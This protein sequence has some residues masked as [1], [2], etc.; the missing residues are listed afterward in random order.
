[1][2]TPEVP[3]LSKVE[4]FDHVA[5]IN[6]PFEDDPQISPLAATHLR[7]VVENPGLATWGAY[8]G[9]SLNQGLGGSE[10]H[11][12]VE[13]RVFDNSFLAAY[14]LVAQGYGVDSGVPV[15]ETP[16]DWYSWLGFE[17]APN[18]QDLFN[19]YNE[20]QKEA[21]DDYYDYFEALQTWGAER[22]GSVTPNQVGMTAIAG[23]EVYLAFRDH[24]S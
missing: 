12:T 7:L 14:E 1:M 13:K 10:K 9:D 2:T 16:T 3:Q 19:A 23:A 22:M 4:L 6:Q 11:T 17:E 18:Y 5:Q 15:I 24:Q 20:R 8:V 21:L